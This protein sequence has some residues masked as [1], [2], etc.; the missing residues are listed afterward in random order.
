MPKSGRAAIRM[1]LAPALLAAAFAGPAQAQAP[2]KQPVSVTNAMTQVAHCTLLVDGRVRS[3]LEIRPEKTW[4]EEVDP[5]RLYQL[6]CM[7]GK[8]NSY[9]LEP[10]KPYRVE[11]VGRKVG[12]VATAD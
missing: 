1:L 8:E 7:R 10:G 4:S 3:Y 9:R 6:V 5:R 12:L 2:D 11:A